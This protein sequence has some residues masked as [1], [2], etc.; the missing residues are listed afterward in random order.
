M[1]DIPENVTLEW[2][3][4]LILEIREEMR[5]MR[6]EI[7]EK[8]LPLR[9]FNDEEKT[10]PFRSSN[11]EEGTLPLRSSNDEATRE[12]RRRFLEEDDGRGAE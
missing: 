5:A 4:H 12:L 2:L 11:D 3:A 1:A 6:R 10:L 9:S 7:Q 8:M